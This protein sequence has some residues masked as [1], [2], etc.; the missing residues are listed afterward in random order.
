LNTDLRYLSDLSW[1]YSS[2]RVLQIANKLDIF[3][4]LSKEEMPTEQ[5]H[6]AELKLGK[7]YKSMVS[8]GLLVIQDFLLNNDK[9][10]PLKEALFNVMVGVFS[11]EELLNEI[12]DAGFVEAKVVVQAEE[13]GSSWVTA[14]K[15]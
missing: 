10:G 11:E 3:T 2:A 5:N 15:L 13:F 4:I 7:A 14:V 6:K 12:G 9:T 1:G 8:G